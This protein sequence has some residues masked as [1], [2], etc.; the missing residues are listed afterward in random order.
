MVIDMNV[1]PAFIEELQSSDEQLA[2]CRN[3]M[4]LY[5]TDEIS[6][7]SMKTLCNVSGIDKLCLLPLD[8]FSYKRAG[9]ITCSERTRIIHCFRQCRSSS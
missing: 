2:F 6:I 4:G 1:S 3:Q 5:K 9:I 8:L 7:Q